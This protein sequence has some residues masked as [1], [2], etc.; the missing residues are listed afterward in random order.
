[1]VKGGNFQI[2]VFLYRLLSIVD[3]IDSSLIIYLTVLLTKFEIFSHINIAC[4]G[5]CSHQLS[6][7]HNLRK[8]EQSHLFQ[9]SL[10]NFCGIITVAVE[11][12]KSFSQL[13]VRHHN[14][15]KSFN[16]S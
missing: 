9:T 10:S 7:L 6:T 11:I 14:I 3:N 12:K 16:E 1:M 5:F 8:C 15:F 13:A 4:V 2:L